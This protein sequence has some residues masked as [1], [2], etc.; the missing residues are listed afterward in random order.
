MRIF[1]DANILFSGAQGGSPMQQF[2]EWLAQKH[3]LVSSEYAWTEAL[4]N[5]A[6]KR[7]AWQAGLTNLRARVETMAEQAEFADVDLDVADRPI[8]GAA[9]AARCSRLL[10]GDFQHFGRLMGRDVDGVRIVSARLLADELGP[11]VGRNG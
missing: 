3:T 2:L 4:R 11:P 5:V 7:P 6:A 10:T 1:L 8:L 9:I